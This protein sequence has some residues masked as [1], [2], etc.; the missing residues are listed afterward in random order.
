MDI[1]P[2]L[3][4]LKA[5]IAEELDYTLEAARQQQF[6]DGFATTRCSSFPDVLA[7]TRAS[8]SA[9]G[10]RAGRSPRSGTTRAEQRDRRRARTCSSCSPA[11]ARRA[12]PRRPPPGQL[13]AARRRP[14]R[15]AR[16]RRVER[17]P[18]GL[19]PEIGRLLGSP[20][21]ATP[22]RGRRAARRRAS[23]AIDVDGEA[24]LDYLEPFFEPAAVHEF[25]FSRAW[26]RELFIRSATPGLRGSA[27][28]QP[29]AE[30]LLIHRV[31]LGGIAVL[32]QSG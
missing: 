14:A 16:L 25:R 26:M 32:C 5:R 10:S 23:S 4:E 11:R 9:S 31:W 2:L 3:D 1:K 8:S 28:A 12:A 15:R 20:R 7:S 30:Y 13:P 18:D 6:A 19:P 29:A 21:G 17:L 27:Q 24:L 22:T